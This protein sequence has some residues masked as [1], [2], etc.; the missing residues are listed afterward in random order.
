MACD[1]DPRESLGIVYPLLATLMRPKP[2][3]RRTVLTRRDAM[4]ADERF[5]A[6]RA[7]ADFATQLLAKQ[8]SGSIVALYAPKGSEVDTTRIDEFAR[9][10]GLRVV[11]PRIND[12]ERRLAFHEVTI[13]ELVPATFALREP[14]AH[15]PVV[16]LSQI[17]ALFVPGLAFD[18]AGGRIGWGRGYYDATLAAASPAALRIGLAFECQVIDHVPREPHDAPLHYVVTEAAIY[19]APD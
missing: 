6:S 5:A 13:D 1:L 12:G 11:Y 7:I 16:E 17:T 4:T 15:A 18:R 9:A 8:P 2:I 14:Q 3:T 19:R 10:R